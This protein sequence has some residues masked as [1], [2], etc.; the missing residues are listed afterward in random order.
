MAK[1][2]TKN[3]IVTKYSGDVTELVIPEGI[4]EIGAPEDSWKP[5]IFEGHEELTSVI[6]PES[7]LRIGDK[8]FKGCSGLT[9]IRIPD[10]V[11][12]IGAD[13]F[14]DCSGLT[15][16]TIPQSVKEIKDAQGYN[17]KGA[18]ENCTGLTDV[19]ISGTEMHIGTKAFSG[20][21]NLKNIFLSE[22]VNNFGS[23]AFSGCSGIENINIP[24]S[25]TSIGESV[26]SGCSG[27]M[28][29][30]IPDS[31]T[32]IGEGAFRGCSALTSINI[33]GS[34][35]K[36]GEGAFRGC[37]ALTSVILPSGVERIEPGTFG[38]CI[39]LS[40]II[41]PEG[42]T[43]ISG[44]DK[45]WWTTTNGPF[46]GCKALTSIHIPDSVTNIGR[47]AFK[48]CSE[49]THIN[50]PN[51]VTDIGTG[52][53]QNCCKL[54]NIVI[55]ENLT[56]IKYETFSGCNELENVILPDGLTEI[57]GNAF[58]NCVKLRNIKIPGS[59]SSIES[60]AFKGCRDLLFNG[61]PFL[62]IGTSLK[63]YTGNFSHV[64][65]P[66]G[67]TEI[68]EGSIRTLTDPF[69]GRREKVSAE[70]VFGNREEI[71]SVKMPGSIKKIGKGAFAGCNNLKSITLPEKTE[72]I[73]SYAFIDCT[74][75]TEVTIP[76]GVT[77]IDEGTFENCKD[78][79]KI[80]LPGSVTEIR[81]Y[82]FTGCIGLEEIVLPEGLTQIGYEAFR[83]CRN[84]MNLVIPENMRKI[85]IGAFKDCIQINDISI[86]DGITD[87]NL[88]IFDGCSNLKR[89]TIPSSIKKINA[90]KNR[91]DGFQL[92]SLKQL[93]ID[94]NTKLETIEGPE[95]LLKFDYEISPFPMI[96]ISLIEEPDTKVKYFFEYAGNS[97]KY[98]AH[99]A[100]EYEKYGRL[101]RSRILREAEAQNRPEVISYYEKKG[102]KAKERTL[103]PEERSTLLAETIEKGTD[104]DLRKV[105]KKHKTFPNASEILGETIRRG[106]V[107]KMRI[108]LEHG[109]D[110]P[111]RDRC[112]LDL[113]ESKT[114]SQDIKNE[115]CGF[116]ITNETSDVIRNNILFGASI[117]GMDNII[118]KWKSVRDPKVFLE[119]TWIYDYK[120]FEKISDD[121]CPD[122]MRRIRELTD[123]DKKPLFQI[124]EV[125]SPGVFHPDAVNY[126]FENY[127]L[128][129]VYGD[130][131]YGAI[132]LGAVNGQQVRTLQYINE[133]FINNPTENIT[134]YDNVRRSISKAIEL[135]STEMLKL[136]FDAGWGRYAEK[137]KY[138][139]DVINWNGEVLMD[140]I[141]SGIPE[142]LEILFSN[143]ILSDLPSSL[144]KINILR[145]A[146]KA[147][148]P[149]A[150]DI[151]QGWIRTAANRDVLIDLAVNEKKNNALSWL[152]EYKNRTANP[153]K[154][155][156]AKEQ[157]ERKA[158]DG[159]QVKLNDYATKKS[160][161]KT[162]KLPDGTYG[163]NRYLGDEDDKGQILVIPAI[164]GKRIIT[165]IMR[166]AFCFDRYY[167]TQDRHVLDS[168]KRI[169][170]SD[171]ITTIKDMAFGGY[172]W[173]EAIAIPDSV[174]SIGND[175]FEGSNP[176]IYGKTGSCA[177]RYAE[178]SGIRFVSNDNSDKPIPD[179][180][181]QED[182][183]IKYWGED[184]DPIIPSGVKQIAENAFEEST[185]LQSIT[186]PTGVTSIGKYAFRKCRR[187]KKIILP[188][189]V[190]E[191][192][193]SAF[194]D[195][196]GLESITIPDNLINIGSHAFHGC[197][198]LV[199]V[200]IPDSVTNIGTGAFSGCSAL[201]GINIPKGITKIDDASRWSGGGVFE[202]C[203]G[204]LN[205]I[206]PQGVTSIGKNAFKGCCGLT[207]ITIP[208][209][210][211]KIGEDAFSGCGNL[212]SIE[213]PDSVTYI[214][215]YAFSGCS[216]LSTIIIP[217]RVT[218]VEEGVFKGCTSLTRLILPETVTSIERNSF[219]NCPGLWKD[220]SEF[221]I[222][223]T[224]LVDYKGKDSEVIIPDNV[225]TIL[226]QVFANH[227]EIV[228]VT[229]PES[230]VSIGDRAFKGCSELTNITLPKNLKSLGSNV[231]HDCTSLL[232]AGEKFLIIH[233]SL[234][235]YE[236]TDSEVIIPA[237]V[238]AIQG[239]AFEYHKE[240]I[241]V[242]IPDSVRRIGYNAF[243]ECRS[244]KN[245]II[246]EGVTEI[247]S[248]SFANCKS[249]TRVTIPISATEISSSAFYGC[250]TSIIKLFVHADSKALE[251][252]K[253]N[254]F[255]YEVIEK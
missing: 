26:F 215:S 73:G 86:P 172:D 113:L 12:S 177:Q 142:L 126:F 167:G 135:N 158:L 249:L 250:P 75:L 208:D 161:W 222:I 146:V 19:S 101:Q 183:L 181:I 122:A 117:L 163:I 62:V 243:R 129:D 15:N 31:V 234:E 95:H 191:I 49:L 202:D 79:K 151:L 244:L 226:D 148:N 5:G 152:L 155:Q 176:V 211:T 64:E 193:E 165:A 9:D 105:L 29:I 70:G 50:I 11:T 48:D 32:K 254:G 7:L 114:I 212:T 22:G 141:E 210:V 245:V 120:T 66:E 144:S 203:S 46:E 83:G 192:G 224:F 145:A 147:D 53:F 13:A 196:S 57:N 44:G 180:A 35:T 185:N 242:S 28:Y 156:K 118:T 221:L 223:N 139:D 137:D 197:S 78:L 238:K 186:V 178:S 33:P 168:K 194:Y 248:G 228:S 106:N 34:V 60:S 121:Q 116:I 39:N 240:I 91:W 97:D 80:N 219:E 100:E 136:I 37:C 236:G 189:T 27:L 233:N 8:A 182:A 16:L 199:S 150:L 225:K 241:S 188:D 61:S 112:Y 69:Y 174:T 247:G 131:F 128:T 132:I 63:A 36:I 138:P 133:Y 76:A 160:V 207:S 171:G 119:L 90:K 89:I 153:V 124:D 237:G 38:G 43:E 104:D 102:H 154:E 17:G 175:V 109:I 187:L 6:L 213:I 149:G 217:N 56:V 205:M 14:S 232:K 115:L 98:P 88:S 68:Q 84:L 231:F 195:C 159:D 67:I 162:N 253:E 82:A 230:V 198:K 21:S 81:D 85:G 92:D 30:N 87:L 179:F 71:S 218:S 216:K 103:T 184:A 52:V 214:G 252:A 239:N 55:P 251:Y 235:I 93:I 246:P 96:P 164:A 107:S 47:H 3:G 59:V 173:L 51:N 72:L 65:I 134:D 4:T 24:N 255:K 169:I 2:T 170:I 25:M 40:S 94:P 127:K 23:N 130:T 143:G 140:S 227:K 220:G 108:M 18:F 54:K 110:L 125:T 190:T 123:P 166:E 74:N 20:C 206:I 157:K 229:I 77:M 58:E 42:V 41:I 45:S 99:I 1:L 209:G 201:T 200:T 111:K 204:L 10:S